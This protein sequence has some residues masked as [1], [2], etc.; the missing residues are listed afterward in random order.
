[1]SEIQISIRLNSLAHQDKLLLRQVS[2]DV[3]S[4]QKI[5]IVGPTGSGKTSLL[6]TLNLTNPGYDGH[7]LF[8]GK[9]LRE[10][11][12]EELRGR[13]MEVMQEPHLEEGSVESALMLPWSYKVHS[14]LGKPDLSALREETV[15]LL[16]NFGLD[17]SYLQKECGKLSG[18][19]KQRVALVRAMQFQPEVLLLDEISSALDQSTSGIISDCLFNHYPGT[20]VAISHDPLW[21]SRWNRIWRL[22]NGGVKEEHRELELGSDNLGPINPELQKGKGDADGH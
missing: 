22:E 12:P 16:Q 4:G 21:Q 14:R 19:E 6:H 7:I 9:D 11:K 17:A 5:L 1:M 3:Q 8:H 15:R 13:I 10:H 18:G 2:L 20:I